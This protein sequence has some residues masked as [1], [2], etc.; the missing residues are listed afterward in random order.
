MKKTDINAALTRVPQDMAFDT[1]AMNTTFQRQAGIVR[2]A[3]IYISR[4][5]FNTQDIFNNIT[6]SI[7][8]FCKEMGYNKSELYRRLDIFNDKI[9]PP[10]LIDG[11]ECDGLF[12]YALFRAAKENI[13]FN[14]WS[15]KGNPEI[16]TYQ[17]LKSLE[18]LYNKTTNK[19]V[20]RTYSVQLGADIMNEL[21]ARFFILDYDD[22]RALA[23]KSSDA[24]SSY[25]NFYIFFAKMVSIAR[26]LNQHSFTT[27]VNEIASVLNYKID[28]PK[29]RKQSVKRALEDI[30]KKLKDTFTY[31]FIPD[32]KPGNKSKLQYHILFLFSEETL[33]RFEYKL[34][35]FWLK[36]KDKAAYQF[37]Q[38]QTEGI[39]DYFQRIHAKDNLTVEDFYTWW[40]SDMDKDAKDYIIKEVI[41]DIFPDG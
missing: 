21:F 13:V 33:K 12:E 35:G 26:S 34:V 25:R 31:K 17:I 22:Y 29:N 30:Q 36:I 20:K 9:K 37:R 1:D 14:R 40:F 23:A 3:F 8:D 7:D 41:K 39:S 10:K 4:R 18:I 11:H 28:E 15:K 27:N 19:N 6:F 32:P 38:T 16:K 2:D 5:Q 24:T